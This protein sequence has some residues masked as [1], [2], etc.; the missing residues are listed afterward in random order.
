MIYCLQMPL[1]EGINESGQYS[2]E[3]NDAQEFVVRA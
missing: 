2:I 1:L 3:K